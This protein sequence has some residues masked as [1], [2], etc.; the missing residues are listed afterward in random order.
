MNFEVH[1]CFW[2]VFFSRYVPRSG[3]AGSHMATLFQFFEE[4]PHYFSQWLYQFAFSIPSPA[5]ICRPFNDGHSA[6][7]EVTPHCSFD[8]HFSDNEACIAFKMERKEKKELVLSQH[9]SSPG[10]WAERVIALVVLSTWSSSHCFRNFRDSSCS[11]SFQQFLSVISYVP[12]MLLGVEHAATTESEGERKAIPTLIRGV[13]SSHDWW[14]GWRGRKRDR[15]EEGAPVPTV[16]SS[17]DAQSRWRFERKT[18]WR[19]MQE[20][21]EVA[22]PREPSE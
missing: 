12:G 9:L 1:I 2:I 10:L 16:V 3:I 14:R 18:A 20:R 4:P 11:H 19:G 17:Q 22:C 13:S 6:W 5:F 7:C 15:N 8:L 21:G